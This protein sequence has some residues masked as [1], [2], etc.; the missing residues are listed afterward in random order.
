MQLFVRHHA[1]GLSLTPS[2][3]RLHGSARD[4]LVHAEELAQDAEGLAEGLA[5]DLDLG[6]FVTFAPIVLPGVLR[7]LANE[8]PSIR[9]RPHEAD[10]RSLQDG[11][12]QGRFELALTYDLNLAADIE[13]EPVVTVPLYAAVPSDHRLAKRSSVRLAELEGEPL[14]LLGLPDSRDHFL[15]IFAEA[16]IEPAIAYETRSFEMVRGLV[17]NGYGYSILHSRAPHHQALDGSALECIPLVEPH[18]EIHM[19]IARLANSR[20]TRMGLAVAQICREHLP[21]LL[22]EQAEGD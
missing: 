8:H 3:R 14:V 12:R 19:G 4:L 11:L 18:R 6:C 21:D 7:V 2:G 9:V 20:S 22:E 15:S 17:A 13:F 1:Q 16:G 5:G 10:L